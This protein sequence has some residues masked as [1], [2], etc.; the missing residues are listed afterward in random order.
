MGLFAQINIPAIA[1]FSY[2]FL[3][4]TILAAKKSK[5]IYSFLAILLASI[6]WTGGSMFMR[7]LLFP[8]VE[9]WYQISIIGL[10]C[11]PVAFYNFIYEFI[12]EKGYFLR[13]IWSFST[14][15]IVF[16]NLFGVFLAAPSVSI[17]AT[18]EKIFLYNIQWPIIIIALFTLVVVISMF[19][20]ITRDIKRNETYG[21]RLSPIIIGILILFAGNLADLI[22]GVSSTSIDTLA[23]I[24]NAGLLFYALYK[25]RL[26]NMTL[27]ASRST[28]YV[29]AGT[30]VALIFAYFIKPFESFIEKDFYQFYSY[31][32][33]I[34]AISFT[35]VTLIVYNGVKRLFDHIFVKDEVVQA[36]LLKNFSFDVSKSL[37]LDEI[38]TELVRVMQAGVGVDKLYVCMPDEN[39]EFYHTVY[40]SS[41]LDSQEFK[42][43]FS[44][45][46]V[47]W[48]NKNNTCL[49][50]KEFQR[51][52]LFKS[53]WEQEKRQLAD[54]EIECLVPLN[55]D[56][57]LAGILLLA[58]KSKNSAFNFDDINFL[59]SINSIA[60]I[61][62]KNARMYEKAY[63]EARTDDLTG[64]L[65]R[66]YF[67]QMIN[68]EFNKKQNESIT[69]LI[70]NIDDFKL[71]NQL[72]GNQEGD[73]ALRNIAHII[74]SCVG[75]SGVTARYSGKEF[76]VIL[77]NFDVLSTTL[78]AEEI[79][80]QVAIMNQGMKNE[81]LKVLTFSAGI[82]AYPYG[83]NNVKQLI[84]N[85]EM[86]VFNAKRSGKNKIEVY[87]LKEPSTIKPGYTTIIRPDV[88]KEYASTIFAL[89]A[90]ID[91]K[92]HYTFDHSQ[93]VAEYAT[94]LATAIGL[95]DEH[96]EIIREAALLHDIG[97]I[98]IPEN[99]LNKK[100]FL[101]TEESE[102]MQKHV[103]N[104]ISI[105]KHL[106]SLDYVIPGVIGHHERWDGKGYP[107][108][109]AGED[110]PLSAR[111]LAIADAFDA[112]TTQ[113]SYK[114]ALPIEFAVREI[115]KN[116]G[117][118]FDPV[119]AKTF[120]G[121]VENQKIAV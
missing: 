99:I 25:R 118:Q 35:L 109:I 121:L 71:Y 65:N 111:C 86:T 53:M 96:I 5:V 39:R 55:C 84:E 54:L 27:L 58:K 97:K 101:T 78:L 24:L 61:A 1:L 112:M 98:G 67:Y 113:R 56:D 14:V 74:K 41:P 46:C 3:F 77:P 72:Y 30:F 104:S 32:T 57:E 47:R 31:K 22:P 68:D 108:G 12:G 23:G 33:L 37:N 76:A 94:I 44:N 19:A 45:P 120:V 88:Y 40:S 6:F 75:K 16:L 4:L 70:L 60:S 66:K 21:G 9:F 28:T 2:S 85:V 79:R 48:L 63:L 80:G 36:Q 119:L 69:L 62:I 106:P 95:N 100:G 49:L 89:T 11:L 17:S 93:K 42:F 59:E 103:E 13:T 114:K 83:A 26:F 116:A 105:I 87:S 117:L 102:I 92:D 18:G 73:A 110:I 29:I 82:C 51:T 115:S 107:R 50:V 91:T 20:M 34:I 90:A 8:G 38:L 15:I 52:V 64:L 81:V 43:S 7:L 10:F